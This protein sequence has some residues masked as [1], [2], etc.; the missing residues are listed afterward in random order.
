MNKKDFMELL[1][2]SLSTYGVSDAREILL[3]FEQHF[4]DGIAAGE[5]EE[6]VCEK[7][8]DPIEIAKQY[9]PEADI[10]VE[11]KKQATEASAFDTNNYNQQTVP[12]VHN[13]QPQTFKA[14]AGKIIVILLVDLMIF[15]WALPTLISLVVSLYSVVAAF[16]GSGIAVFIGGILM[17]FMDTTKWFFTTLS[18]LST[19]LFGIVLL[20]AVPLLVIA[21][22][23]ATKGV[24]NV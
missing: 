23:A 21:S 11:E 2:E 12:P 5:T 19:S 8:G 6:Q 4:E 20:A 1:G 24:I 22:I 16:A 18:P 9:I 10:E 15:T 14:D 7:L 13:P 3:D 17:S